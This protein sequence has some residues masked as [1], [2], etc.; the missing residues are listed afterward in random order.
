MNYV[1]EVS[2]NDRNLLLEYYFDIMIEHNMDHVDYLF[3]SK[4]ITATIYKSGKVMLQGTNAKDDYLMFAE[5]LGFTAV[6]EESTNSKPEKPERRQPE[7]K[8]KAIGSDE[9]GTG[10]FFGPVVVAAVYLL[11]SDYA[12]LEALGVTDSKHLSD[13]A[14]IRIAE[15][16]SQKISHHILVTDNKKYN[17]LVKLG[18]NMN[19]IKAYLH[20]HAIMKLVAKHKGDV[21]KVVVDQFCSPANYFNY[22]KGKQIYSDITF[23]IEAE[24]KY[25]SVAAASILA[26]DAFL[27]EMA[28]LGEKIGI[29]IPLG[30]GPA[31]DLIGKRIALEKGFAIFED[32]AKTNFKNLDKIKSMM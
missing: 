25:L 11:P 31:V 16:I 15:Q 14:I 5:L 2:E 24:S 6:V 7:R 8:V 27:K 10:D 13:E 26:R 9:V 1:F 3:K 30:A 19:K 32:I 17:D 12:Y 18:F 23:E 29:R 22:L 21:E 4:D 28:K 20:N